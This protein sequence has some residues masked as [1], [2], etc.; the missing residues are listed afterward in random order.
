MATGLA[1]LFSRVA[2]IVCGVVSL[3]LSRTF[4]LVQ[5][6]MPNANVKWSQFSTALMLT[7]TLTLVIALFPSSWRDKLCKIG[8]DTH[9]RSSI[10]I[11]LLGGF[12]G[13]SYLLTV[14]LELAP[15]SWHPTTRAVFLR[16]PACVLTIT[17]DPSLGTV[18]LGLAL[19]NA[20][21][22]GSLGAGL[23]YFFLAVRNRL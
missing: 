18:L 20:A 22:F 4:H 9:N 3:L 21:V 7:G 12:A 15:L 23:G 16:C 13:F 19:L 2:L 17:V 6:V 14:E 1:G 8:P 5:G 11:Q 10:P